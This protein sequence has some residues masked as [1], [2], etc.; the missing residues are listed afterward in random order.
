MTT[1]E[2]GRRQL[3]ENSVLEKVR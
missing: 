1:G 2:K 3:V